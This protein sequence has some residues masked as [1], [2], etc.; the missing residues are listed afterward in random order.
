[1]AWSEHAGRAGRLAIATLLCLTVPASGG[2][3]DI[4]SGRALAARYLAIAKA[5]NRRLGHDFDRL[6]GPDR[7]HL[8]RSRADLRDIAAA[9][10]LFDRR[11]VRIPFGR[12]LARVAH[13]LYASNQKRAALTTKAAGSTSLRAVHGFER[14]LNAANRP[15][16]RA[17]RTLRRKLGLPPPPS[18]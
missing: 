15:V 9:E 2:V 18:G 3:A 4:Q 17:V 13:A 1:M 16:E 7:N 6:E 8:A 5:G 12:R 11:L 14:R 10:R